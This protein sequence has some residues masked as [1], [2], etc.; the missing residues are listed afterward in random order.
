MPLGEAPPPAFRGKRGWNRNTRTV[1]SRGPACCNCAT[2]PA[3]HY[4]AKEYH[5]RQRSEYP[6]QDIFQSGYAFVQERPPDYIPSALLAQR[7][8]IRAFCSATNPNSVPTLSASNGEAP[9][10]Q[11][12]PSLMDQLLQHLQ[13]GLRPPVDAPLHTEADIFP[14]SS[15]CLGSNICATWPQPTNAVNITVTA[16][17]EIVRKT[18]I[19]ALLLNLLQNEANNPPANIDP[20]IDDGVR[21]VIRPFNLSD[22]P[23]RRIPSVRWGSEYASTT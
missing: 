23:L 16:L 1:T 7:D 4:T 15:S 17:R 12:S 13:Q 22:Y 5:A 3:D 6:Q 18:V 20:E 9:V 21:V 2:N 10:G 19:F 14:Q 11:F 8:I